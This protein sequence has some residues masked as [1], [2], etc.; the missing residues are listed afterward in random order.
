MRY[1]LYLKIEPITDI[2][3]EMGV[4]H[5]FFYYPAWECLDSVTEPFRAAGAA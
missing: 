5:N 4:E 2:K 1:N 3:T